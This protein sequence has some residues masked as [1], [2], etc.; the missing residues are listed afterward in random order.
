MVVRALGSEKL[1]EYLTEQAEGKPESFQGL[2]EALDDNPLPD[3][4]FFRKYIPTSGGFVTSDDSGYHFLLFQESRLV[5][6]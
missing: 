2:K 1:K 5:E 6:D 4:D 3:Y